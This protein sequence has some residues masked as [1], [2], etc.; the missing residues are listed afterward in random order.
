MIT[1]LFGRKI[2]YLRLSVTDLCNIRCH[3]CMPVFGVIKRDRSNFLTFEEIVRVITI[4]TKLGIKRVRLTGGEPLVRKG[5]PHLVEGLS[6]IEGLEEV[7][8]TTNGILLKPMARDLRNAGL[9]K[10]NIHL[11]TLSPERFRQITRWGNLENVLEGIFEARRAAFDPIKLNM[12]V[13][14]GINDDEVE[15]LLRFSAENGLILR[16]IELMPIGPARAMI[17]IHYLPLEEVRRR[18]AERFTLSPTDRTVGSGPAIYHEVKEL[19]TVVGFISPVS[20]PFCQGCN[21]IR[22]AADGRF[23]DCLAYEGQFSLR[24]SLRD[25]SRSDDQIADLLLKMIRGKREWHDSFT[26]QRGTPCMA[27]IGG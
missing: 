7:L 20:Q 11:D 23:Q 25:P 27:G 22:L 26:G 2:D 18:L 17:P 10:I 4:L 21:R 13:Q 12:V 19:K 9:K 1:D 16:L 8:L 14:K 3:Y 6:R 5:L 15:S 24:E